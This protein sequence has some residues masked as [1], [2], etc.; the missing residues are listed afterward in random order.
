MSARVAALPSLM[1]A[2]LFVNPVEVSPVGDADAL[3][4]RIPPRPDGAPSGSEFIRTVTGLAP[5]DREVEIYHQLA[6]GNLPDFLRH[7]KPVSLEAV[8]PGKGRVRARVWVMPDYLAIGSNRDFVRIPMDYYTAVALG[9]EWGF[10]LPTRKI[11][12]AIYNQADVRVQ[13]SPMKPG[14]K[15][16]SSPYYLTHNSTIEHQLSGTGD[17]SQ[18]VAGHKK[19]LVLTN[20]LWTRRARVAIYGWHLRRGQVIQPLSTVHGGTY[21]DYSHGVRLISDW[22]EVDGK[23]ASTVAVL[24]DPKLARLLTSEGTIRNVEGLMSL[25]PPQDWAFKTSSTGD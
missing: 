24:Q 9:R 3:I 19:D 2:M 1:V 25:P 21:A 7:L 5:R 23:Q 10:L 20:R 8:V 16:R 6:S 12:D 14:P 18:L 13:P 11:V 22:M 15:M 17:R 4:A